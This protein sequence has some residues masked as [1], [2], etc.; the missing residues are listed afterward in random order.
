MPLNSLARNTSLL[1]IQELCPPF[2]VPLIN[3]YQQLVKNFVDGVCIFSTEGTTQGNP[4]GMPMYALGVLLLIHKL[5]NH[6]ASQI[7]Y[8]DDAYASGSLQNLRQWWNDLLSLGPDYGYFIKVSKCWLFLK[9][10]DTTD[11]N[12]FE[13]T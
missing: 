10:N 3:T 13:G 11:A 6:A 7:W 2:S 4:M 9:D 1:N 8:A 12:V 5:D